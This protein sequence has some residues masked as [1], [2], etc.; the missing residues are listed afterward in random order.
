MEL[1]EGKR[2]SEADRRRPD[3]EE[4]PERKRRIANILFG[5]LL[6]AVVVIVVANIREEKRFAQLLSQAQPG[7]IALGVL[8]QFGTYLC[9]AGVW[10]QVLRRSNIRAPIRSLIALG[11]AKLFID[12]VIPTTGVGGTVVVIR[13]LMRR[14]IPKESATACMLVDLLSFYAAHIITVVVALV[15]LAVKQDL[16]PAVLGAALLFSAFAVAIP[17]LVLQ[18]HRR[19]EESVPRWIARIGPIRR[20]AETIADAPTEVVSDPTVLLPA[21]AFQLGVLILDAATFSVMLAALG[22]PALPGATFATFTIA[23]AVSTIGIVPGGLG[24]FE[25]SSVALL[26]VLGI[27]L[28][29][30]LAATLMLR[31]F[32]FWLPMIPGILIVR[33]EQ[34]KENR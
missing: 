13:G 22:Q 32:T 16:H 30:G 31:A 9:A 20:L 15:I 27:P 34:K 21:T 18:V 1:N 28:S 7:W 33:H 29:I 3:E 10:K 8:F 11:I 24:I 26:R 12:Q 23:S 17:L 6:L 5:V 25:A 14:G 19:G 4:R 2:E